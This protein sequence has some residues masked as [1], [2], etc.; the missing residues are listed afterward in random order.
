VLIGD[1]AW[2]VEE[3]FEYEELIGNAAGTGEIA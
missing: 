2:G 3:H 1:G